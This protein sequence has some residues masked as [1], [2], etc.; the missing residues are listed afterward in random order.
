MCFD[1]GRRTEVHRHDHRC[2]PAR[3]GNAFDHRRCGRRAQTHAADI[4][5]AD[6]AQQTGL[7]QCVDRRPGERTSGI[8]FGGARLDDVADDPLEHVEDLFCS[9]SFLLRITTISF[10]PG[11]TLEPERA[12]FSAAR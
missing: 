3:L 1:G 4:G 6:E 7:A 2:R 11:D 9:H 12:N 10:A 8:Y 5:A